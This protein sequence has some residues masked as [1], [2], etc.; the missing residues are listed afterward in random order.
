MPSEYFSYA[1]DGD[2]D[3]RADIF[4]SVPDALASAAHQ[5]AGKGWVKGVRWGYEVQPARAR[6]LL[7]RGPA[8]RAHYRRLGQARLRAGRAQ[9]FPA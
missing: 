1:A 6:R 9:S 2:G 4:D 8:G 3:G 7:A 5:L